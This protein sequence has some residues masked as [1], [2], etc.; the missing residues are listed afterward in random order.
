M[1]VR[2]TNVARCSDP[3]IGLTRLGRVWFMGKPRDE[4]RRQDEVCNRNMCSLANNFVDFGL[5]VFVDT[6]VAEA[7]PRHISA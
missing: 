7:Q 5:T 2:V 6:V 3:P 1:T 4:A